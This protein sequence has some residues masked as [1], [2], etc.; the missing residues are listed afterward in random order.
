MNF[1]LKEKLKLLLSILLTLLSV[2]ISYLLSQINNSFF[3][4]LETIISYKWLLILLTLSIL[5]LLSSIVYH[6]LFSPKQPSKIELNK[7]I[8]ESIK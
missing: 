2:V 4:Y 7:Q 6:F 1:H 3:V 8:E 5:L